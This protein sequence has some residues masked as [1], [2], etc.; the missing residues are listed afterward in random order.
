M[1]PPVSLISTPIVTALLF[2]TALAQAVLAFAAAL[3]V[4]H[5]DIRWSVRHTDNPSC[6]ITIPINYIPN[7][8]KPLTDGTF[9]Y[10]A[11]HCS[12]TK[13]YH[14]A[15]LMNDTTSAAITLN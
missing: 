4:K 2:S 7:F 13:C 10:M 9:L 5:C 8:Y 12:C 6:A 11:T 15:F 3:C 1:V 14:W